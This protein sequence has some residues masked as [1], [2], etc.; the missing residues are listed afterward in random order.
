MA[1]ARVIVLGGSGR[2]GRF[3]AK[4][5]ARS[6]PDF[7][8]LWQSRTGDDDLTWDI[9]S[10]PPAASADAVLCLAGVTP[11][12]VQRTG[13]LMS[14]NVS[15]GVA[16]VEAALKWRARRVLL[17]S[18]AAVYGPGDGLLPEDA[19]LNPIN[20]YGAAKVEM[21]RA[22]A[23]LAPP[24][25]CCL[26]IGNVAGVDALLGQ[27]QHRNITL[28]RFATGH[29]PERSYIGPLG[30]ARVFEALLTTDTALPKALNIAAPAP[31]YMEE[32]LAAAD[33]PFVW[34]SAPKTAVPSVVLDTRALEHIA[35]GAAG[36]GSALSLMSELK[37]LS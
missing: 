27:S 1:R 29:G 30:I 8:V 33:I 19:P 37:T 11:P 28:D 26:R 34:Q 35:P 12:Y 9:T 20:D 17:A 21:E 36:D 31:V 25:V 16:A 23:G 24:E 6:A 15:L 2:I 4:A 22:V 18:S 3:L 7:E 5:W 10:P 32:L 14:D 13:T